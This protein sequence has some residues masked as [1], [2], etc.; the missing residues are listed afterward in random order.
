MNKFSKSS[1]VAICV[2]LPLLMTACASND[3][4]KQAQDSATAA[5]H[6]AQ[7]ATQAAQQAQAAAT[8]AQAAA[9]QAQAAAQAASAKADKAD[10]DTLAL[11]Q[12]VD[13][14]FNKSLRKSSP[15]STQGSN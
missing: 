4:V 6:Q 10:Q 8:Q 7:Q 15:G 1:V 14:M 12:K 9:Q 13:Q 11:S 5:Q 3:S 2:A